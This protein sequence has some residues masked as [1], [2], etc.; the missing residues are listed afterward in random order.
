MKGIEEGFR[1]GFNSHV[2]LKL[3]WKNLEGAIQH[4]QVVD[5]YL[6]KEIVE[7]R[8]VG[9]FR[10][11]QFPAIQISRFGVVPKGHQK[12]KWRLIIDLSHPKAHSV[13]DGA[14]RV[15]IHHH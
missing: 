8:V 6:K 15:V 14:V 5:E 13:N 1:I 4:P 12:D 3:A 2:T 9:P 10:K 7:K 11:S